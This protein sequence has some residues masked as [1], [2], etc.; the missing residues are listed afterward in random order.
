VK[1]TS[2]LIVYLPDTRG[3]EV[4]PYG[5]GN[6]KIGPNVY[7]YSRDPGL[8]EGTCPGASAEC[9]SICYAKRVR[10]IVRDV[11]RK[12]SVTDEVPPIPEDCKILRAH[13]SGDFSSE[14]YIQNWIARLRERPDVTFWAYTRSWRVPALLPHLED[15]RKLPNVQLF[16]S[17]DVSIPE[18]PPA[19]W[20]RA[21]IDGDPRAGKIQ[22]MPAHGDEAW[23]AQQNHNTFDGSYSYL[24]P[25]ETKHQP[26][27]EACGYCIDGR[28]NDVTFL[29]H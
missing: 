26:N 5:R 6:L 10:G 12:N 19:G 8:E 22:Y 9:E 13:I 15:L 24:C 4:S 3:V 28:R 11:W 16:A 27:C 17:M 29:K 23:A 20:R 7:T 1:L 18:N 2:P 14:T 21:W 25:E